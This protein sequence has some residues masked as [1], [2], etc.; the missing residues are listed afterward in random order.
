MKKLYK[1]DRALIEEILSA[2]A[3]GLEFNEDSDTYRDNDI[4]IELNKKDY[5]LLKKILKSTE[6]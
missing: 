2:I 6:E 1:K 3:R 4:L 5:K